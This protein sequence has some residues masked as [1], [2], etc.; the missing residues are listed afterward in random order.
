[1]GSLRQERPFFVREWLSWNHFG[2]H[3]TQGRVLQAIDDNQFTQ[4]FYVMKTFAKTA[5]LVVG[6][7][8]TGLVYA[9]RNSFDDRD[10]NDDRSDRQMRRDERREERRMDDRLD[11]RRDFMRRDDEDRRYDN[12]YEERLDRGN[13]QENRYDERDLSRAYDEGFEDGQRSVEVAQRR[14]RRENYKNFTFGLYGGANSTR[15]AGEDV[16]G[17]ALAGRLGYQL[18]IFVRGGGRVYGQIGAEYLTSS[19]DFFR[20]GDG[21]V[22]GVKDITSNVDQQYLHIPAYIGV[23]LAQSERGVSAVRLQIGAEYATPLGVGNNEFNFRQSDFRAATVNGLANIGFD[24][25]PLFIDFVY[26]YG[27][28]DVL[29][30][31]ENTKRRI[32]GVNVGFKF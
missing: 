28:A 19:S 2:K 13:R 7:C 20:A 31:T 15:F 18:G 25:G 22:T 3:S 29:K 6:V 14:E 10:R 12:R 27:F 17:N 11:D 4:L 21:Q 1:M 9:Q 16:E 8:S 24:A 5:L 32:L 26:H 23:K 30:N